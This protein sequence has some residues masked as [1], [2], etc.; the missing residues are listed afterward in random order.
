MC[1]EFQSRGITLPGQGA[2]ELRAKCDRFELDLGK[3]RAGEFLERRRPDDH[4]TVS[5]PA[6][7]MQQGRGGLNEA[8]PGPSLV[9]LN[10]RTPDC[11]QRLVC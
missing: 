1:S 4:R 11:F 3:L 2:R 8:L 7:A 10:N 9:L 6:A 5:I